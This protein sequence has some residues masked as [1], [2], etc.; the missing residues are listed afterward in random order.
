[1]TLEEQ[2]E[3]ASKRIHTISKRPSNDVL[4][5]LYS[6]HKQASVGDVHGDKPSMFDFVNLA[7]YN[8]WATKRGMSKEECMTKYV[9]LVNQLLAEDGK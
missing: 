9:E 4:L 1:M 5:N 6:L 3:D 8:A 2:F 7:K